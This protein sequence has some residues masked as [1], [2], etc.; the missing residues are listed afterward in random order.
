MTRRLALLLSLVS[1]AAL[2]AAAF[3]ALRPAGIEAVRGGPAG[4]IP[5]SALQ[6][7]A[8]PNLSLEPLADTPLLTRADLRGRG[9]VMVN[10]WASWCVPCRA[11]HP[12]LTALAEAGTPVYGVNYRDAP[13]DALAFLE[14]LGNPFARL[15]A[16]PEARNG[17]AWDVSALPET[18]FID[19]DG[20]VVLHLRGPITRRTLEARIIPALEAAGV[21]APPL[22]GAG[23]GGGGD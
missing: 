10:F 9:L 22:P 8:A 12:L 16:D 19:D 20:T 17:T 6:G 11:E 13:G 5:A 4:G 14:E 23:T 21:G 18:F 2:V 7:R 1:G 15:G 3:L